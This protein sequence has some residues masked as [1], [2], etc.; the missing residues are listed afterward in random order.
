MTF[1]L[2]KSLEELQSF[3]STTTIGIG[4]TEL[5]KRNFI[6]SISDYFAQKSGQNRISFVIFNQ[7]SITFLHFRG[8]NLLNSTSISNE[9]I[10]KIAT[11]KGQ[12]EDGLVTLLNCE[13]EEIKSIN[14]KGVK[15]IQT[16]NFTIMPCFFGVN[17]KKLRSAAEIQWALESLKSIETRYDV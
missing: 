5:P 6:Q 8:D 13:V 4:V 16:R 17:L 11:V 3:V 14:K 12:T 10:E 7:T 9:N 1:K 15:K 2:P